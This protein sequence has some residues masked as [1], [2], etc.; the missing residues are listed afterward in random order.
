MTSHF[1]STA[2]LCSHPGRWGWEQQEQAAGSLGYSS[3]RSKEIAPHPSSNLC[4]NP[5]VMCTFKT[6]SRG[7][8]DSPAVVGATKWCALHDELPNQWQLCSN[9][10][11]DQS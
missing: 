4:S 2:E 9:L 8:F 10:A 3:P 5:L 1:A 7:A 11:P 6:A